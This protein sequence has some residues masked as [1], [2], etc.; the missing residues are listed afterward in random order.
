LRRAGWGSLPWVAGERRPET[1]ARS[2]SETRRR[3]QPTPARATHRVVSANR[4]T[5]RDGLG[6]VQW[7]GVSAPA[8]ERAPAPP[9]GMTFGHGM[10]STGLGGWTSH[11]HHRGGYD[12][13]RWRGTRTE[14]SGSQ[15]HAA[16]ERAGRAN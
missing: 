5:R 1:A 11:D 4:V 3:Q 2:R 9:H 15:R 6:V 13:L 10:L 14:R 7:G 16:L 8:G 12:P